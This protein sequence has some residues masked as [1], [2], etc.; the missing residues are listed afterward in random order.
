M[1]DDYLWDGSGEPDPD[2]EQLEKLLGSYRYQ[3][4]PLDARFEQQLSARRSF[5]WVKY[6]AAAAIIVMALA[7]AWWLVPG[8]LP[9]SELQAIGVTPELLPLPGD[10]IVDFNKLDEPPV[11]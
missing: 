3:A 5:F 11:K 7:G 4:R 2:V 10:G 1:K 9:E 6:A 8:N